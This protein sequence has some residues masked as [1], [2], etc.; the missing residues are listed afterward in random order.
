MAYVI[1]YF[2][3]AFTDKND[4]TESFGIMIKVAFL[5]ISNW[6]MSVSITLGFF[7]TL[8]F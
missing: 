6:R 1:A 4:S 2:F 5:K 3:Y 8:K 7:G